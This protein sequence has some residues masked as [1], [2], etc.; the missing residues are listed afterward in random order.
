MFAS[1]TA[2]ERASRPAIT[3]GRSTTVPKRVSMAWAIACSPGAFGNR[4]APP[5]R[6]ANETTFLTCPNSRSCPGVAFPTNSS[7]AAARLDALNRE[8]ADDVRRA[9]GDARKNNGANE[10]DQHREEDDASPALSHLE[11]RQHPHCTHVTRPR[12]CCPPE[13]EHP[14]GCAGRITDRVGSRLIGTP[15]TRH[16]KVDRPPEGGGGSPPTPIGH[17]EYRP[18]GSSAEH[19]RART[20][21]D[22]SPAETVAPYG[23]E[24]FSWRGTQRRTRPGPRRPL[25]TTDHL[26]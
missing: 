9:T 23:L 8:R 2:V 6:G 17:A 12:R 13:V 21:F 5:R 3:R 10:P 16:H 18:Q 20:A 14:P 25:R 22:L 26:P 15:H 19:R 7:S 1:S 4:S 11:P 24:R